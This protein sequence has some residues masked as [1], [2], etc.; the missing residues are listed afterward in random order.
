MGCRT[1]FIMLSIESLKCSGNC[2]DVIYCRRLTKL[3]RF[4]NTPDSRKANLFLFPK[5]GIQVCDNFGKD[6][7]YFSYL[8]VIFSMNLSNLPGVGGN[9]IQV[10]FQVAVVRIDDVIGKKGNRPGRII[11]TP[12]RGRIFY[13]LDLPGYLGLI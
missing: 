3:L 2:F 11:L 5:M 10:F 9:L 6:S 12:V 8:G 7:S 13:R 1:H 4:L